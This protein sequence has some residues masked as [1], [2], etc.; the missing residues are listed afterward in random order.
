M[1]F[2]KNRHGVKRLMA[3][4]LAIAMLLTIL[5]TSAFAKPGPKSNGKANSVFNGLFQSFNAQPEAEPETP[6]AEE[7][8]PEEPAPE[9][10]EAPAEEPAPEEPAAPAEEP[11]PEEP[12]APAEEPAP[13]EPAEEPAPAI[14]EELKVDDLTVSIEAEEGA[15]PE[16]AVVSAEKVDLKDVQKAVDDAE[17]VSGKVLY[18]V[19]ITF[20]LDGE[21]LQPAEGKTVKVSFSAPELKD[22]AEDAAVVHIDSE[23]NEAEKV[24]TIEAE[25]ADVAIEAEKF[26]VYAVLDE[27]ESE[28]AQHEPRLKVI[29]HKKDG[30]LI[31]TVYVKK[32][33]TE[34]DFYAK[35][36]YNPDP[37]LE[38]G[39]QFFGW[40]EGPEFDP[41]DDEQVLYDSSSTTYDIGSLRDHVATLLNSGVT[42]CEPLNL[43]AAVFKTFSVNY[44]DDNNVSLGADVVKILPDQDSGVYEVNRNYV[45]P[46]D[47][48]HPVHFEGWNVV[49]GSEYITGYTAGAVYPN[50]T[51]LTI[52]G[53]V[54]FSVY[55][56]AGQWLVFH[57]NG[58]TYVAPDF[59]PGGENTVRPRPDEEMRRRG[60]TF[61]GWYDNPEC[62]GDPYEFGE[63]ITEE[64]H[65]YAKWDEE[66]ESTYV[67]LI[68]RQQ[69]VG[70]GYDFAEA[71]V[72]TGNTHS[73]IDIVSESG[74]GDGRYVTVK[75]VAKVGGEDYTG[76]HL[77]HYTYKNSNGE[78]V[79]STTLPSV[80]ITSNPTAVLN[81]YYDR[82]IVTLTFQV[83]GS[84]YSYTPTTDTTGTQY[85]YINGQ[86]V[87]LTRVARYVY[88]DGGEQK[89]YTDTYYYQQS[90]NTNSTMYGIVDGQVVQLTRRGGVGNRYYEYNGERY[91]G[92]R[93]LRNN[94]YSNSYN[95]GF[96]DGEMRA[97]TQVY[98]YTRNGETY[99]GTRY[100]RD[101]TT[102]WHTDAIYTGR[103]GSTLADNGYTWPSNYWWYD[104][105]SGTGRTRTTVLDSFILSDGSSSQT[106]YGETGSGTADLYLYKYVNG[107]YEEAH[108]V[109]V[110]NNA[111]FNISD[112]FDGYHA[113][114]YSTDNATWTA[115]GAKNAT[116]GYYGDPVT[117]FTNLY[118]RYDPDLYDIFFHNGMC[119]DGDDAMMTKIDLSGP[120]LDIVEDIPYG[121]Q[122]PDY[123][124]TFKPD[125]DECAISEEAD[126]VFEGWYL[127]EA[128][129][130]P[131]TFT[132]MPQGLAV[133][134][135]WRQV[136]YRVFLH[137]QAWL[138]NGD[139]DDS[140]SWGDENKPIGEKQEMSFRISS[141][142]KV[143]T[144]TGV[145]NAP[146]EMAGW[147]YDPDGAEPFNSEYTQLR[148]TNV[149]DSPAYIKTSADP[150]EIDYTNTIDK[151]GNV[152][153]P[154]ENTD[155]DR[156]W[157]ERKLDL[158]AVWRKTLEGSG[159][160]YVKYDEGEGSN[161]PSDPLLYLDKVYAVAKEGSDPPVA[162]PGELQKSFQ[163]WIVQKWNGTEFVDVEGSK[164]YPGD[165]F[166]VNADYAQQI[167]TGDD[168]EYFMH[169]KAYYDYAETP[170]VTHIWWYANNGSG[171]AVYN[172]DVKK[173][174]SDELVLDQAEFRMN[175]AV[176]IKPASTFTYTDHEFLGWAR[177]DAPSEGE[178]PDV[179]D[180]EPKIWLKYV[181]DAE[182]DYFVELAADGETELRNGAP[183]KYVA[184]DEVTPYHDLVAV[185][186][187]AQGFTV[188][189][190]YDSVEGEKLDH[191][192]FVPMSDCLTS[193]NTYQYDIIDGIEGR[194]PG[195][196][197]SKYLYGGYQKETQTTSVDPETGDDVISIL[198]TYCTESGY[199]MT[200][201]VGATYDVKLVPI[202]DNYLKPF[203]QYIQKGKDPKYATDVWLFSSIDNQW[204]KETGFIIKD[205]PDSPYQA[206]VKSKVTI[207][208][209]KGT[210]VSTVTR[211][212]AFV[213]SST[214]INPAGYVTYILL[215]KVD[216]GD[217][218]YPSN[219]T[220]EIT[221]YWVTYD[222]VT[223]EGAYKKVLG[224]GDNG[225]LESNST[226]LIS[227]S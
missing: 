64:T 119:Y 153:A 222:N 44:L 35:I 150:D 125:D 206:A 3:I 223:V 25:D 34:E 11:A 156:P 214:T 66:T 105:A 108:H 114:E 100:T 196:D 17:G 106:F 216:G 130:Q 60:Y 67:V 51:E 1:R 225:V 166:Q 176:V 88:T 79:T 224:F 146:Y 168:A 174:D 179:L 131:Y 26:S 78:E 161:P 158:Y 80:E 188:K 101:Y 93:Y 147:F 143:D 136:Q 72:E 12:A 57:S 87:Q 209:N 165:P 107:T 75:N 154:K 127:D 14:A 177:V 49:S 203:M 155:V 38:E 86:Y 142:D 172:N 160:I 207:K 104:A 27:G 211:Q 213:G 217:Y 5:P 91:D 226:P 70:D 212:S 220:F 215:P 124:T 117:G 40:A 137:P 192:V 189:Y 204:Y 92:L 45:A 205:D 7:P 99:T 37:G 43:Y 122:L 171:D 145:R 9:E 33:D 208:N 116:T 190:Y 36:L 15:F 183:V 56:P 199:A 73:N 47:P 118:I 31:D 197:A 85:A 29:F 16:G 140:L 20:T 71:F 32:S 141:G 96:A 148:D 111:S 98:E 46:S 112:K 134:A 152:N 135:K 227:A 63:P 89:Y 61:E 195:M 210:V 22:I 68:W 6:A 186:G 159:G 180:P 59:V 24:E 94:S 65:L 120:A 50:G 18:A 10:P 109:T 170:E 82:N 121:S 19:D 4:A 157:V 83:S 221:P 110:S 219:T 132:T 102:G 200:P 42:E 21:E 84:G 2:N 144:P 169:L 62:T 173:D 187:E 181:K 167:G 55:A 74:S 218:P 202:S 39:E 28:D 184:A 162:E 201:E 97:L 163:Y 164:V 126:F 81:I 194:Y 90:N 128:C 198:R 76:F 8:A 103:Y 41:D 95:L 52:S 138:A 182:G 115:V 53:D 48:A 54:V 69:A 123:N 129:T 193:D 149:P 175:A 185:W 113:A 178:Q 133:Y 77:D 139:D 13:E 151:F 30:T 23:T 191:E 58:G